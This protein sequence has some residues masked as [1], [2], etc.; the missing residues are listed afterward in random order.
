MFSDIWFA[1]AAVQS[2]VIGKTVGVIRKLGFGSS[3][4]PIVLCL[5]KPNVSNKAAIKRNNGRLRSVSLTKMYISKH[6]FKCYNR[7]QIRNGT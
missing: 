7:Q 5:S 2:Q 4:D 6:F 1:N 3:S